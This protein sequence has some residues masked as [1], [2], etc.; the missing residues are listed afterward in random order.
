MKVGLIFECGPA[1]ADRAV[2]EHLARRLAPE[3]ELSSIT[4]DNKANP[5]RQSG[6]AAARLL[7]D[8]CERVIIIWDLHPPGATIARAGE[9]IV[10]T[11]DARWPKQALP[12]RMC[13]WFALRKN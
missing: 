7:A 6:Q 11:L 5:V 9:K 12:H 4:L 8:G 13:I 3:I 1:G 2:C 10:K